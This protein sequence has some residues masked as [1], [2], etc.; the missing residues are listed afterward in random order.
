MKHVIVSA[1]M[2]L[3][4][5][6]AVADS[7]ETV[8]WPV[9]DFPPSQITTG[10]YR[11]QGAADRRRQIVI[12]QMPEF[13]HEII[14]VATVRIM[15]LFKTKPNI[16]LSNALKTSERE[17]F[18]AFSV[19]PTLLGL[20][21]GLITTRQRLA[22]FKSYIGESGE[23]RLDEFLRDG[24]FRL[25]IVA[26]RSFG[27]G[28]D[29]VL[30]KHEKDASV[31]TVPSSDHMSSRLLK[32]ANQKEFDAVIG[33]ANELRYV[34]RELKLNEQDFIWLP[35]QGEPPLL[36][37]YF[38]CSKSDLGRRVIAAVDRALANEETQRE[39]NAAYRA[40][41]G[42]EA[43]VRFDALLKQSRTGR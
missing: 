17:V 7:T 5:S 3:I 23:F 35:V 32:L 21:N 2:L 14:D 42:E 43:A 6:Q 41:L 29:P 13:R 25:A 28:I 10:P 4:F 40:W 18:M 38:A 24:K 1:L 31:V 33:Y 39:I 8:L 30:K 34:T 20:P 36:R 12:R 15:D 19:T 26:G 27:T 9:S 22:Q 11:G 16:C 37:S